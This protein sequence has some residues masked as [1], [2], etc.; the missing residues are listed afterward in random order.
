MQV[1]HGDLTRLV[2]FDSLCYAIGMAL[3]ATL[4]TNGYCIA[5]A[6]GNW[7]CDRLCLLNC[8]TIWRLAGGPWLLSS[9]LTAA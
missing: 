8:W 1:L 6:M 3:S 4:S 5:S 7:L 2:L 9:V